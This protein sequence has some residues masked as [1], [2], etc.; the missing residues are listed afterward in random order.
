[1]GGLIPTQVILLCYQYSWA[2]SIR[3]LMRLHLKSTIWSMNKRLKT[4]IAFVVALLCIVLVPYGIGRELHEFGLIPERLYSPEPSIY[5]INIV[6]WIYG[7]SIAFSSTII[8]W[9][10]VWFFLIILYTSIDEK[11][12][13]Q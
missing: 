2:L 11:I 13:R 3:G 9:G 5:E 1:M 8:G 7:A 12:N 6:S 4:N 10:G